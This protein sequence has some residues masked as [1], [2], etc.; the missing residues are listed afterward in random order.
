MQKGNKPN[1][2]FFSF[3]RAEFNGLVLGD[4]QKLDASVD[5]G[6]KYNLTCGFECSKAADTLD[7]VAHKPLIRELTGDVLAIDCTAI[8]C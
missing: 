4:S 2:S 5:L 1:E 8:S 6:V 3:V 7:D